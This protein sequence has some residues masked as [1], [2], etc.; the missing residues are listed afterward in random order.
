MSG[1]ISPGIMGFQRSEP[2]ILVACL[3]HLRQSLNSEVLPSRRRLPSRSP[4]MLPKIRIFLSTNRILTSP[5]K[6]DHAV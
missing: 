6:S 3:K 5:I 2:G 4:R 1:S